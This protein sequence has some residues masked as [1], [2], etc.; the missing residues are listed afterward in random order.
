MKNH[1]LK[2][3]L[4]IAIFALIT[5]AAFLAA[6][7]LQ[8]N[9]ALQDYVKSTGILGVMVVGVLCG[10][11]AFMPIPPATF[12]PLFIESGLSPLM[13]VGGFV[14]GTTIADSIGYLLGLLGQGYV[15]YH[16][17]K[18]TNYLRRLSVRHAG[19]IPFIIF[20]FFALAPL[21]NEIIL[22]PLALIGYRYKKLLL[23]LILGNII[24][25]SIMVFGYASLFSFLF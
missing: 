12:A 1:H 10:L 24:H 16:H 11:N 3:I 19:Y 8:E 18:V 20:G 2:I 23:P 13:V 6:N 22:I 25:Q 5:T 15:N 14:I 17:P 7:T 4:A 9:S 21:P